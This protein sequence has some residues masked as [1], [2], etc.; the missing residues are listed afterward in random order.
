M[1]SPRT[2]L[3]P[4]RGRGRPRPATARALVS[5]VVLGVASLATGCPGSQ[6]P[7]PPASSG[8]AAA[9]PIL[10]SVAPARVETVQRSVT[11]F[12]TLHGDEEATISNKVT[13]RI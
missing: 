1:R 4:R 11:V 8:P 3:R 7:A 2:D 5:V 9:K 13:G 6:A 10:V 12:G